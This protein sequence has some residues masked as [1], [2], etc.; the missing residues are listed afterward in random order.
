MIIRLH[1]EEVFNT[2]SSEYE[3][4]VDAADQINGVDGAV[5]E[6]G[7]RR[8]GSAKMIMDKLAENR[9][10]NRLMLCIDPYGNIEIE[11]T[12][13]NMSVHYPGTEVEGDPK[14]K[15]ITSSRRFD[16]TNEMRNR[17]IPSLYYCGYQVGLNF[18][19]LCLE[20]FEF[21]DRFADGFPAYDNEKQ[22]VNQYAL[23]FFDGPHDDSAVLGETRFFV[24]RAPVG[25]MFVY[26]DIWMYNHDNVEQLLFENGFKL[27]EKGNIKAS[28]KKVK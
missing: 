25:A 2:D 12:N 19:F 7:T 1:T 20:D 27:E 8:G 15:E 23:V 18:Q 26:D 22:L 5:V 13:L 9:D 10:T 16:Y 4:L 17:I 11:C 21:F 24:S 14:S 3:I 28:Y 6:I